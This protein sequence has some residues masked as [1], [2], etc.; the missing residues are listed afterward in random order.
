MGPEKAMTSFVPVSV[1]EW[2]EQ[3]KKDLKGGDIGA[4]D[5]EIDSEISISPFQHFEW[6][7][8]DNPIHWHQHSWQ[9]GQRFHLADNSLTELNHILVNALEKGLNAPEIVFDQ[10]AYLK[11]YTALF[12]NVRE[13]YIS[14]TFTF[15]DLSTLNTSLLEYDQYLT[16]HNV[17]KDSNRLHIKYHGDQLQLSELYLKLKDIYPN[18][19]FFAIFESTSGQDVSRTIS[20]SKCIQSTVDLL[21]SLALAMNI[22]PAHLISRVGWYL[23][24][25]ISFYIDLCR[26]RAMRWVWGLILESWDQEK[27]VEPH[28]DVHIPQRNLDP[29]LALIEA[30]TQAMSSAMGGAHRISILMDHLDYQRLGR[31]IQSIMQLESK[32]DRLKDPAEGS[33]YLES[34]TDKMAR[35]IWARILL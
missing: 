3:I 25:S 31:N 12:R 23:E 1:Q 2:I 20:S 14:C 29:N 28:F 4:L 9:I 11:D 24:S 19:R 33:Y 18:W 21:K 34:L 27:Y 13:D 6:H 32:I 30:T 17:I 7:K 5:W 22:S 15:N 16:A 10:P 8:G 35:T 26:I